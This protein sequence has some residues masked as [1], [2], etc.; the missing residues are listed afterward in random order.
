[1][2]PVMRRRFWRQSSLLEQNALL[3]QREVPRPRSLTLQELADE[4]YGHKCRW[5]NAFFG[6]DGRALLARSR[7]C[8]RLGNTCNP[9]T[10]IPSNRAA[11]DSNAFLPPG[12]AISLQHEFQMVRQSGFLVIGRKGNRRKPR[13]FQIASSESLLRLFGGK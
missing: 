9:A 7:F 10:L 2:R 6:V 5:P 13:P 11:N 3:V 1:M 12:I 8:R 4:P